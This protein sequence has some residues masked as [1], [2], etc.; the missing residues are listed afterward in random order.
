VGRVAA[1]PVEPHP[2][3][4]LPLLLRHVVGVQA[5][6]V[7]E[8]APVGKPG[9]RRDP[10]AVDRSVDDLSGGDVEHADR[11]LLG[12]ALG[13]LVGEQR[14][15]GGGL[16]RVERG[17]PLG[18]DRDRID[19][20]AFGAVRVDGVQHAVLLVGATPHEE[21]PVVPERR[22]TVEAGRQQRLQPVCEVLAR[23]PLRPPCV[24][25]LVLPVQPGRGVGGAGVLE[26]AVRVGDLESV[27]HVH[28]VDA[29]RSGVAGELGHEGE[30]IDRPVH[31]WRPPD[32]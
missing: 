17:R 13:E 25:Q 14:A 15:V 22:R 7:V 8:A 2:A 30:A 6:H 11:R 4:V 20:H 24:Q 3:V 23:R 1:E 16:V 21:L 12:A 18:V 26:P 19:E 9:H 28:V 29:V 5:T 27:D 32:R 31:L 10:R